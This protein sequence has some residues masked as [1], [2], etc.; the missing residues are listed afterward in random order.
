MQ[1]SEAKKQDKVHANV[2]CSRANDI[3]STGTMQNNFLGYAKLIFQ[4][5]F[6]LIQIAHVSLKSFEGFL[7]KGFSQQ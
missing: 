6:H 7:A 5:P 4:F 1:Q 2:F 3:I